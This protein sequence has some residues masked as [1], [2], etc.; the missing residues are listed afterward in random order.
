MSADDLDDAAFRARLAPLAVKVLPN[1]VAELDVAA[2]RTGIRPRP[3]W[4][5]VAAAVFGGAAG[6]LCAA[7]LYLQRADSAPTR[8]MLADPSAVSDA[9]PAAAV[10]PLSDKLLGLLLQRDDAALATGDITAA[11]LLYERA[12]NA[13]SAAAALALGKTYDS[14]FLPDTGVRGSAANQDLAAQ[15][16]RRA[17]A[18]GDPRGGVLVS[19]VAGPP[20]P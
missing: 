5:R 8:G 11:R 9:T 17:E 4:P 20:Q 6:L 2:L 18:L 12:A 19:Q 15:W 1:A 16:Y 3:R 10:L 14:R 7:W 13:G